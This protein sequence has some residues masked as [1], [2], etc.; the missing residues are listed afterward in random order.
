M[1]TK[2]IGLG[3]RIKASCPIGGPEP[4]GGVPSVRI[5]QGKSSNP[6]LRKFRRKTTGNSERLCR[7]A[8]QGIESGT[9]LLPILNAEFALLL[10]RQ[11][12]T[13]SLPI[14]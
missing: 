14:A 9:S 5:F 4:V 7:Q 2:K 11:N 8:R 1:K 6:Y 3:C 12:Q 10:V 13:H